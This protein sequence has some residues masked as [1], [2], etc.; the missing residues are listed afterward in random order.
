MWAVF[1][2]EI[3][4]FFSS[5][6]GYLTIGVL[7][8]ILGLVMWVF[9]DSSILNFQYATMDQLFS[10]APLIFMFLVPAITMRSFSEEIQSGTIEMLMTKPLKDIEIV[11]GKFLA[12]VVLLL[13]AL[14]PT[15]IYYYSIYQLGSP[16]GN[17][18][19]GQIFGSYI[20]LGL[21]G[22]AFIS[23][24]I[25]ASSLSRNQI[26]A[27]ILASFLCFF[28]YWAFYYLSRL[29][30]FIGKSDAFIQKLGIDFHYQSISRG[31]LDTRDLIYFLSVCALF[32]TFTL[33]SIARRK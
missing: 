30:V 15:L 10:V 2:K 14:V 23:I 18:D 31:V 24:G 17:I 12:A 32:V 27:F 21:L 28:F 26:V 11:L 33:I 7:L 13:I 29:P 25:F 20:G 4:A 8:V 1:T 6:I 9:P 3:A 19:S 22:A 16:I 5:L